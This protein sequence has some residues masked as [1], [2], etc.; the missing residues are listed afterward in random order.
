MELLDEFVAA[1][2]TIAAVY[3]AAFRPLPAVAPFAEAPWASSS[4]WMYTVRV[5]ADSRPLLRHFTARGIQTRPLW[6][7]L[8]RSPAHAGSQSYRVEVADR[9]Y[10]ESLSLPCSVGLTPVQQHAVIDAAGQFFGAGLKATA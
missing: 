3:D 2:R 10:R 5:G 8:H 7:P 6:Q 4:Y 1:K 9:L